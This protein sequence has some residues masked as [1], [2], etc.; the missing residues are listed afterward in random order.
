M[1]ED[2]HTYTEDQAEK[3]LSQIRTYG[4]VKN[5]SLQA[6]AG[7][8]GIAASSLSSLMR[9]EY[10]GDADRQLRKIEEF[11]DRETEREQRPSLQK[12]VETTVS[13]RIFSVLRKNHV[14]GTMGAV[15]GE[16][17]VGKSRSFKEYAMR[18]ENVIYM[19]A[20]GWKCTPAGVARAIAQAVAPEMPRNAS[21][22]DRCETI[23]DKLAG[24]SKLIIID[25]A[26]QIT[27]RGHELI[28]NL[29][30]H[31][32]PSDTERR[33][34][35]VYG[36]TRR[37]W[38]DIHSPDS[39]YWFEQLTSRMDAGV[40][41]AIGASPFKMID[42]DAICEKEHLAYIPSA[43]VVQELLRLANSTSSDV[44]RPSGLR[45][46]LAN[47]EHVQALMVAKRVAP[48]GK[49]EMKDLQQ[50]QTLMLRSAA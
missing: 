12:F 38:A 35:I 25:Q 11:L 1:T 48:G 28:Q 14:H 16:A 13:K 8:L 42:I 29:W 26:H 17:G 10:S 24:T 21:T 9:R 46:A 40:N 34:G 39:H 23:I 45:S 30:D 22:A 32:N 37:F 36:C 6:L 15:I 41:Y 18:N 4:S 27:E 31:L 50:A 47:L 20:G 44:K 19:T 43:D 33:V 2:K 5:K 49:I 7:L 3:L